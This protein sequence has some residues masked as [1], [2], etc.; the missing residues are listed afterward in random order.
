MRRSDMEEHSKWHRDNIS[1]TANG[2]PKVLPSGLFLVSF[3]FITTVCTD[4]TIDWNIEHD[5]SFSL[6]IFNCWIIASIMIVWSGGG[7]RRNIPES[8]QLNRECP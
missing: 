5:K 4:T 8:E 2:K 6:H 1:E 3:F 7:R